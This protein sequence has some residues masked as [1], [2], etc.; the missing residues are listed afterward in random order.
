M[1]AVAEARAR[2]LEAL[3]PGPGEWLPLSEALDRVLAADLVAR[4]SQPPCAVSAMDGY[5]VRAGETQAPERWFGVVGE[6]RAGGPPPPPVGAGQAVRIFTGAP[7]PE[8]ADAIAIQENARREGSRVRFLRACTA[9]EFVRPAGL[10]FAEGW[11]GLAAG[12]LLGPLELGLAG[13]MGHGWLPVRRRPRVAI[14][15]T[16]D[17]LVRPGEP[18]PPAGIVSS[19]ST[20]LAALVRRWGGEPVD[21]GIAADHHDALADALS[22]A[23]GADLLL[24]TGGASVGEYD[25]LRPALGEAGMELDFW[26]IA[27]RPGKPLIFGKV[28]GVPLLG[29]PGNPVS[30]AVCAVVF[31]RPVL[32]QLLGRPT[33]LPLE[34]APLAAPLQA[35]DEREE[36]MRAT[37]EQGPSG[38]VLRPASRQDSSMFATLARADA[39]VVRPPHAPP[40]AAGELVPWVPLAR[41]LR[42]S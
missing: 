42:A 41:V 34:S 5:A 6:S 33:G 40:A 15:A 18:V 29:L 12:M 19:N 1:L 20:A 22:Q 13:A 26:K 32:Q 11:T 28:M 17:E 14:L 9:G 7:L 37:I 8:G 39:L 4:R 30:A 2:I 23:R 27:M 24:T 16:G 36:Y 3:N 31:L 21:L 25:L 35:N 10:D 38:P